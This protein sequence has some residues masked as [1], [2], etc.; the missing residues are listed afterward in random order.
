LRR[1]APGT[2][3]RVSVS[4]HGFVYAVLLRT[5][6]VRFFE[7]QHVGASPNV[8]ELQN[9]KIL[10]EVAM[11]DSAIRDGRWPVVGVMPVDESYRPAEF[12]QD[13]KGCEIVDAA[14][15]RAATVEECM[16]LERASIWQPEH[17][18]SR[19]ADHFAGRPNVHVQEG[20]L[21]M[22]GERPWPW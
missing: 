10:F 1:P 14:G 16:G 4:E 12:V 21:R 19:L 8:A 15:R 5:P 7:Q 6:F 11:G 3:V 17:I 22:P 13:E 9:A 18:E 2:I 20:R